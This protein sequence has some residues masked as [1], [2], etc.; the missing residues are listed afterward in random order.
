MGEFYGKRI[1]NEIMTIDQVPSYW[2][3]KAQKWL[4]EN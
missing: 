4:G 1:R 2:L 3:A